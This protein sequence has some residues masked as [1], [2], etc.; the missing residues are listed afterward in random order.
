VPNRWE[1]LLIWRPVEAAG[2]LGRR[3]SAISRQIEAGEILCYGR[4]GIGVAGLSSG[5][6][7][8]HRR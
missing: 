8:I 7:E 5:S 6:A 3:P 2:R 1:I 4:R